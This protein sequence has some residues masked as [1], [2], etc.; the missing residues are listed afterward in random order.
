MSMSEEKKQVKKSK[1]NALSKKR[2]LPKTKTPSQ[3]PS[4]RKTKKLA[5]EQD[6][7]RDQQRW[8]KLCILYSYPNDVQKKISIYIAESSTQLLLIETFLSL[9]ETRAQPLSFVLSWFRPEEYISQ[10][11]CISTPI[12]EKEEEKKKTVTDFDIFGHSLDGL[13]KYACPKCKSTSISN[14]DTQ[15]RS[16]DEGMLYSFKCDIKT[17]DLYNKTFKNPLIIT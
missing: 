7:Q 2:K 9:L 11:L 1:T 8:K 5:L 4:N 13:G 3:S 15:A 6:Q 17:C 16:M 10:Q 14:K 12:E